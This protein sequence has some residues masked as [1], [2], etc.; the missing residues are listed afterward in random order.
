[1]SPTEDFVGSGTHGQC[2]LRMQALKLPSHSQLALAYA[3]H[4]HW[5]LDPNP[6]AHLISPSP[7]LVTRR[8]AIFSGVNPTARP[9]SLKRPSQAQALTPRGYSASYFLIDLYNLLLSEVLIKPNVS[10]AEVTGSK[11]LHVLPSCNDGLPKYHLLVSSSQ[12]MSSS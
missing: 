4:M 3:V 9:T 2:R 6:R 11:E 10:R 5:R 7:T 1:M 12:L 8:P